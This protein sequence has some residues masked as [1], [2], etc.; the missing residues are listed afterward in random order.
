MF[1]L[2]YGMVANFGKAYVYT[3]SVYD[4]V[5]YWMVLVFAYYLVAQKKR[6]K[7]AI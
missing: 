6:G 2:V 4:S 3:A 7:A 5:N 1:I